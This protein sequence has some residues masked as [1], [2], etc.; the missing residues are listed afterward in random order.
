MKV[1]GLYLRGNKYWY[2]FYVNGERRQVST[3]E[4]DP[5]RAIEKA[6]L[7]KEESLRE[8]VVR[9][10]GL[11][12]HEATKQLLEKLTIRDRSRRYIDQVS[13]VM[14]L[15]EREIGVRFLNEVTPDRLQRWLIGKE[16]HVKPETAGQYFQIIKRVFNDV[17]K[18]GRS[19]RKNPC[20]EVIAREY[21]PNKQA[22]RQVWIERDGMDT[23]LSSCFDLELKYC[24]YAGFHAGL[25]KEEVIM[26]RPQWFDLRGRTMRVQEDPLS[27]WRP[28]GKDRRTIPLT[29]EFLAF[30]K[31]DYPLEHRGAYM[32]APG[33]EQGKARYRFDFKK[34]FVRF[35]RQHGFA[36]YTFHDLRRSFASQRVSEGKSVYQVAEWLGDDVEIVQRHYGR[37]TAYSADINLSARPL[38][39]VSMREAV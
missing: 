18:T 27:G 33:V 26:S 20:D 9:T 38:N 30:L 10:T 29:D 6:R 11:T 3:E 2:Q 31:A 8:N 36:G 17:I 22:V 15:F 37:L 14:D 25:R 35:I 19:I 32:I 34:R 21:R 7:I 28:K 39:V 12:I 23:L 5:A 16:K 13:F 24:L 4:S 1:K